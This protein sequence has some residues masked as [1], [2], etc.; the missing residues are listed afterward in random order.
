MTHA[1][2]DKKTMKQTLYFLY[3]YDIR[4]NESLQRNVLTLI[5]QQMSSTVDTQQEVTR[6]HQRIPERNE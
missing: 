1:K 6:T 4:G 3:T 5:S 2:R